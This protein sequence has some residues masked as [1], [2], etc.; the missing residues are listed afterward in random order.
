MCLISNK[1]FHCIYKQ[2]LKNVTF[3]FVTGLETLLGCFC[4]IWQSLNVFRPNT[5]LADPRYKSDETKRDWCV[6][7]KT[8]LWMWLLY[9][10]MVR[11][12]GLITLFL[13]TDSSIR[14]ANTLLPSPPKASP[15]SMMGRMESDLG[16]EINLTMN[17][18]NFV[19]CAIALQWTT[20]NTDKSLGRFAW[21]GLTGFTPPPHFS[22]WPL[23]W[24]LAI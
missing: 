10:L 20:T 17:T 15:L 16:M 6:I 23:K 9:Y 13:T 8:L 19:V 5:E 1:S 24:L 7:Y 4:S 18:F 2:L 11:P 12:C 3:A 22:K 21:A 14:T